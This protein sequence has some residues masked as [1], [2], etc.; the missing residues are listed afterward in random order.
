[1]NS[2]TF[3]EKLKEA[4]T[5]YKTLY[6]MGCF[7]APMNDTNKK[8][9]TTNYA[10]NA[11]PTRA[12]MIQA[13]D[14]NT[15][16]FDCVCLIKG[17]LWGWDGDPGKIYGGASYAANGVPDIG[18]EGMIGVCSDVSTDFSNLVPGEVVWMSGHIG[19]YI[20]DGLAVECTPAWENKV[21]ITAC[22]RA[23]AGYHQRNWTKHGKLPYIEY[24]SEEE[25]EPLPTPEEPETDK[26]DPEPAPKEPETDKKDP[27]PAPEEPETDKK[28]PEPA[29]EEP[30]TGKKD[31]KP[32][33]EEP[34][35]EDPEP[36]TPPSEDSS[37]TDSE[38]QD[39]KKKSHWYD[40]LLRILRWILRLFLRGNG[41]E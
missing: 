15:F 9:Y 38:K 7:G 28:D 27:E 1:M 6:V 31:P 10:Y 16:G 39:P 34:E 32:A 24:V 21:Q 30:E 14:S 11:N 22:N 26:K 36:D 35:T 8:R 25:K 33:P 19:V 17:I 18:T 40:S 37:Q 13:A 20:G 3:V 4:A 41:S 12:A 23:V 5:Q 2:L 29:P